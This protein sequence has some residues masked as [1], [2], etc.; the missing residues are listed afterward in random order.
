MKLTIVPP[1]GGGPAFGA[2]YRVCIDDVPVYPTGLRL[3]MGDHRRVPTAVF[4][5]ALYQV[6]PVSL[7][8]PLVLIPDATRD[9]LVRLGWTPPTTD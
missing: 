2:R 4:E 7:D 5:I 1:E 9:L 6:E 8:D 3:D